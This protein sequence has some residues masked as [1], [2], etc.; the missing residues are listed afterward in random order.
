MRLKAGPLEGHGL[1]LDIVSGSVKSV[2]IQIPWASLG[3]S[4]TR[5]GA[6]GVFVSCRLRGDALVERGE[7]VEDASVYD[8]SSVSGGSGVV[9]NIVRN[10]VV[11][12]RNVHLRV[13]L[14]V[15]SRVFVFGLVVESVQSEPDDGGSERGTDDASNAFIDREIDVRG[16]SIYV[17]DESQLGGLDSYDG[18]SEYKVLSDF[19]FSISMREVLSDSLSECAASSRQFVVNVDTISLCMKLWQWSFF[20]SFTSEVGRLQSLRRFSFCGRP[21]GK[22]L[23]DQSCCLW[24]KFCH[25]CALEKVHHGYPFASDILRKLRYR[26][27]YCQLWRMARSMSEEAFR[28][29]EHGHVL[30]SIESSLDRSAVHFLR[31]Y[32]ECIIGVNAGR[33]SSPASFWLLDNS[34]ISSDCSF[35]VNITLGQCVLS[36]FD[37]VGIRLDSLKGLF[38]SSK[39][40]VKFCVSCQR[41]GMSINE[42]PVLN[43]NT[44]CIDAFKLFYELTSVNQSQLNI[45]VFDPQIFVDLSQIEQILDVL[46]KLS[47]DSLV[48]NDD[49]EYHP[50]RK[51]ELGEQKK[52]TLFIR[53]ARVTVSKSPLEFVFDSFCFESSAV[54]D[55]RNHWSDVKSIDVG[56]FCCFVNRNSVVD[57]LNIKM[58]YP[59]VDREDCSGRAPSL[60]ISVPDLVVCLRSEDYCELLQMAKDVNIL[61]S[62]HASGNSKQMLCVC[63]SLTHVSLSLVSSS[64]DSNQLSLMLES[65]EAQLDMNTSSLLLR[66]SLANVY[67]DGVLNTRLLDFDVGDES[68]L[69]FEY[70]SLKETCVLEFR[71]QRPDLVIDFESLWFAIDFFRHEAFESSDVSHS[72]NL[73]IR[74]DITR[75]SFYIRVPVVTGFRVVGVDCE[76]LAYNGKEIALRSLVLS[77]DDRAIFRNGIDVLCLNAEG[78]LE[79]QIGDLSMDLLDEDYGYCI[80]LYMYLIEQY[81]LLFRE[82][83]A[84]G[85]G[86]LV[87]NVHK[88][89]L[90]MSNISVYVEQTS[91]IVGT[92]EISMSVG[93]CECKQKNDSDFL[94]AK[95]VKLVKTGDSMKIATSDAV[96]LVLDQAT[97][98]WIY[99][100]TIGKPYPVTVKYASRL[101]VRTKPLVIDMET[102]NVH[103][104]LV[105]GDCSFGRGSC[106]RVLC[107]FH[108]MPHSTTIQM[109]CTSLAILSSIHACEMKFLESESGRDIS[110]GLNGNRLQLSAN[111][112]RVCFSYEHFLGMV[113]YVNGII[114]ERPAAPGTPL[115]VT[116]Y[117][118]DVLIDRLEIESVHCRSSGDVMGLSHYFE[119]FRIK[120]TGD[121][122]K[123]Q[124]SAAQ[125]YDANHVVESENLL[126]QIKLIV[127]PYLPALRD[128]SSSHLV[129]GI[130]KPGRLF[131]HGMSLYVQSESVQVHGSVFNDVT[132][133][134]D[135]VR[136][137]IDLSLEP[138]GPF[139]FTFTMSM[140]VTTLV[141]EWENQPFTRLSNIQYKLS[142]GFHDMTVSDMESCFWPK[143]Y[144]KY[145]GH[146]SLN[147]RYSAAKAS[148]IFEHCR[149]NI[150][151]ECI[152]FLNRFANTNPLFVYR[153]HPNDTAGAVDV[154]IDFRDATFSLGSC[155]SDERIRVK[156][157]MK[158]LLSRGIPSLSMD[159]DHIGFVDKR[160]K[161]V[162]PICS[163]GRASVCISGKRYEVGLSGFDLSLS[164]DDISDLSSIWGCFK[165]HVSSAHGMT[166]DYTLILDISPLS[167]SYCEEW[168]DFRSKVPI[169]R[170]V[171]PAIQQ[172]LHYSKEHAFDMK[173]IR[174]DFFNIKSG[175]WDCMV[176]PV[177]VRCVFTLCTWS[178]N[179][180]L[181]FISPLCINISHFMVSSLRECLSV[182]HKDG[183]CLST[184]L[185]EAIVE[186]Q[187]GRP[188]VIKFSDGKE[189]ALECGKRMLMKHQR[190]F[191]LV[192]GSNRYSVCPSSL[193]TFPVF[194][195]PRISASVHYVKHHGLLRIVT[196]SS[197]LVFRNRTD[198]P[199]YIL[200]TSRDGSSQSL[201]AKPKIDAPF[202]FQR[203]DIESFSVSGTITPMPKKMRAIS[204]ST[205]RKNRMELPL[206]LGENRYETILCEIMVDDVKS[207][208]FVC[209]SPALTVQNSLESVT[210]NVGIQGT[211]QAFDLKP[212]E[213]RAIHG[214]STSTCVLVVKVAGMTS[215]PCSVPLGEDNMVPVA[216]DGIY[217]LGISV[218][219][220][221]KYGDTVLS[222]FS[223]GLFVNRTCLTLLS[224]DQKNRS[225]CKFRKNKISAFGLYSYFTGDSDNGFLLSS[226]GYMKS[227]QSP[228]P[229]VSG[230]DSDLLLWSGEYR[231]LCL[232]LHIRTSSIG[233]QFRTVVV[234][235]THRLVLRSEVNCDLFIQP[236]DGNNRVH[237]R[238]KIPFRRD[239]PVLLC[240]PKFEFFLGVDCSSDVPVSFANACHCTIRLPVGRQ[241][242]LVE[243]CAIDKGDTIEVVLSNA[244]LPQPLM[245]S[246]LLDNEPIICRCRLDSVPSVAE[247]W[248]TS[249]V[250]FDNTDLVDSV[251]LVACGSVI[252]TSLRELS[253]A[254]S[255]TTA[256]GILLVEVKP[257]HSG[258]LV[259]SVSSSSSKPSQG[260]EMSLSVS[261]PHL[262]LSLIDDNSCELALITIFDTDLAFTRK[263]NI[264]TVAATIGAFQLDDMYPT[265]PISVAAHSVESTT[266][267]RATSVSLSTPFFTSFRCISLELSGATINA[268]VNFFSELLFFFRSLLDADAPTP[269]SPT[270][271]PRIM[272][273][274]QLLI[275]SFGIRF[276]IRHGTGRPRVHALDPL[277]SMYVPSVTE[278]TLQLPEQQMRR[279]SGCSASILSHL[280]NGVKP[281]LLSQAL[282]LLGRADALAAFGIVPGFVANVARL[283]TGDIHSVRESVLPGAEGLLLAA[284]GALDLGCSARGA[285][286]VNR[287]ARETVGD[288]VSVLGAGIVSGIR[289]IVADPVRGAR[290]GGVSGAL[291]G[292][293]TG[294]VGAVTR[295]VSGVLGAGA[296]LVGGARKALSGTSVARRVR[297]PRALPH[298]QIL[299]FSSAAASAQLNLRL[300][301]PPPERLVSFVELEDHRYL[302]VTDTRLVL[303]RSDSTVSDSFALAS[304]RGV[305][306][307]ASTLTVDFSGCAPLSVRLPC[308]SSALEWARVVHS[309]SALA[310]LS[311]SL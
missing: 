148:I 135:S 156:C 301:P 99:F 304:V 230:I 149:I 144:R 189:Q 281:A 109:K 198:F 286:G 130:N 102:G 213:V 32:S 31:S 46:Q 6:E 28:T 261:I 96:K 206:L 262:A 69:Q 57:N 30:L 210:A 282:S 86:S 311:E 7:L 225:L 47:C 136:F 165:Q 293:V 95:N 154:N 217:T 37:L 193:S 274:E 25:R 168:K 159:V 89:S 160:G 18:A 66:G 122:E 83:S 2:S 81:Y 35:T 133:F 140:L 61:L 257:I 29:S 21:N 13:S 221:L 288:G 300:T 256:S 273:F 114:S 233:V 103:F 254:V 310:C 246:N 176:E 234:T 229:L 76:R 203:K 216:F 199:I 1:P 158:I 239:F 191:V 128:L 166:I 218:K 171:T 116:L 269:A 49:G 308:D 104:D 302:G 62:S 8:R 52:Y 235:A 290:S 303:F 287:T 74:V 236:R 263:H 157:K 259:I 265:A 94:V 79:V 20:Q 183:D 271:P 180:R 167:I 41:L 202:P 153:Y 125:Y 134:L 36:L 214:Q 118:Y 59:K 264:D 204:M 279:I 34:L 200:C 252:R 45:S 85:S 298:G 51:G 215:R 22:P 170:V 73:E 294:I 80:E 299:P 91:V 123:F 275:G 142:D 84:G 192:D 42:S 121:L 245:L 120:N 11:S 283:G 131:V 92:H 111:Y 98:N 266:F 112:L 67:I 292:A 309:L 295:P 77:F 87:I 63:L 56:N 205:L 249:I 305:R 138:P 110:F 228:V 82:G 43:Q 151:P 209:F 179:L 284:S 155:V 232:P 258:C 296:G 251:E 139:C 178:L 186:N 306:A 255:H 211:G 5:V 65:L 195:S 141:Y 172:E 12:V 107:T 55:E 250:A 152:E 143:L 40:I 19:S 33:Y 185:P 291:K 208:S 126:L 243:V 173:A 272:S 147:I 71:S 238:V 244:L 285:R 64:N 231:N 187:L 237:A 289:G 53:R 241:F 277:F 24:W 115:S 145:P 17:C 72:T 132:D 137:M 60:T 101:P 253:V 88:T 38:E 190:D 44:E 196:L 14:P 188:C 161:S 100:L 184:K 39:D 75:P 297:P 50:V 48:S 119:S 177:D 162:A 224:Y 219:R 68:V 242:R 278:A 150:E 207:V 78:G 113:S 182:Q 248:S 10:L 70:Q 201:V 260:F 247:P 93:C 240:T 26:G 226:P 175:Q 276:S 164:N 3:S 169:V 174:V 222:L 106:E 27:V 129:A 194:L 9:A 223:P 163:G 127:S 97:T 15:G 268:D 16:L 270:L 105:S 90:R 117:Y 307:R 54:S 197:I 227:E 4:R 267:L 146:N 280:A 181:C 212:K 58:H 220:G 23:K 108:Y 124:V